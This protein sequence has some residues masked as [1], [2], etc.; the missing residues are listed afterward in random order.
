VPPS[1]L[2][3]SSPLVCVE[4]TI[5]EADTLTVKLNTTL[6]P[7]TNNAGRTT[8]YQKTDAA[9]CRTHAARRKQLLPSNASSINRIHASQLLKPPV[10]LTRNKFNKCNDMTARRPRRWADRRK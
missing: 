5:H 9:V 6:D 7:R 1:E 10:W 4:K 3:T 8:D 2:V